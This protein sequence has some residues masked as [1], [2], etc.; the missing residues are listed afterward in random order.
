METALDNYVE[1]EDV[2]LGLQEERVADW[3]FER[4]RQTIHTIRWIRRIWG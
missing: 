1:Q 3:A 4:Y 2:D